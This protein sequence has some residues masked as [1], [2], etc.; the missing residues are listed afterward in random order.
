MYKNWSVKKVKHGHQL[1]SDF[2]NYSI[3]K[4]QL[5][6]RETHGS[7]HSPSGS[8]RADVFGSQT[9]FS[10]RKVINLSLETKLTVF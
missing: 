10:L 3:T 6:S 8:L 4:T 1:L 2:Y 7:C 5:D 9:S